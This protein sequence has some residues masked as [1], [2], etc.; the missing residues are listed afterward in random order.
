MRIAHAV[1][2]FASTVL[3]SAAVNLQYYGL[4]TSGAL[5]GEGTLNTG[6]T[7]TITMWSPLWPAFA[8]PPNS[9][10][11]YGLM[12]VVALPLNGS[13]PNLQLNVTYYKGNMLASMTTPTWSTKIFVGLPGYLAFTQGVTVTNVGGPTTVAASLTPFCMYKGIIIDPS[14]CGGQPAAGT[15]ASCLYEWPAS[16]NATSKQP[17]MYTLGCQCPT[18]TAPLQCLQSNGQPSPACCPDGTTPSSSQLKYFGPNAAQCSC[19]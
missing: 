12:E 11:T 4:T 8:W 2:A 7:L 5:L 19:S 16:Q 15:P 14:M 18:A 17:F 1:T 9:F 3:V 10:E 6:D 13:A